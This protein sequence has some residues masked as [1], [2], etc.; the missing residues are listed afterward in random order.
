MDI[1]LLGSYPKK[2][3]FFSRKCGNSA[4]AGCPEH[5]HSNKE[6][7]LT[8]A[9]EAMEVKPN[10]MSVL[11]GPANQDKSHGEVLPHSWGTPIAMS[12]FSCFH[13]LLKYKSYRSPSAVLG[14]FLG[15]M[16]TTD[17]SGTNRERCLPDPVITKVKKR[18]KSSTQASKFYCWDYEQFK[19]VPYSLT[20]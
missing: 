13:I 5:Q 7:W 17:S 2:W 4:S 15:V 10:Q 11:Q 19:K 9:K 1:N 8:K 12:L 14:A 20:S 18:R 3:W 16:V 6:H